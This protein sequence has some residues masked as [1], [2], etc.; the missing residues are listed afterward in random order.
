MK[1]PFHDEYKDA[2]MS[3]ILQEDEIINK[4]NEWFKNP[5]YLFFFT[6]PVG[7][8][9]TYFAS[10]VYNEYI[11]RKMNVRCYSEP[12]FLSH[13][14]NGFAFDVDA[15]YETDR[16]CGC[17]VMIID[18]LGTSMMT[19]WQKEK[20]SLL[21]DL[22]SGMKK[23]TLITSNL[24]Q[25]E[26]KDTFGQRTESRLFASRNTVVYSKGGDRRAIPNFGR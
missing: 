16:L 3:K 1:Y 14:K 5:E 23:S 22:R 7:T 24:T 8:G 4:L 6:G 2:T 20:L 26:I 21:I 18:D 17:D 15:D 25:R 9:K 10:A 13:L 11:E 12:V 19:D